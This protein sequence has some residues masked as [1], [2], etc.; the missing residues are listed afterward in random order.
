MKH[1]FDS[2][3]CKMFVGCNSFRI[4]SDSTR[5]QLELNGSVYSRVEFELPPT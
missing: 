3:K 2:I 1:V 5:Q 4:S